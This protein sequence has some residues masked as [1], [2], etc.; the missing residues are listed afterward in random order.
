MAQPTGTA[1][2]LTLRIS[3]GS[4]DEP[5]EPPKKKTAWI[6]RKYHPV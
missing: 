3:E 6:A 2:R 5:V 1:P 4:L